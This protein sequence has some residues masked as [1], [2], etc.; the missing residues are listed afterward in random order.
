MISTRT[1]FLILAGV[2]SFVW[3]CGPTT[4]TV[5]K[6]D[7][8]TETQPTDETPEEDL[9]T[10]RIVEVKEELEYVEG[11]SEEAQDHFRLGVQKSHSVPPDYEAA[12]ESFEEAIDEEKGFMEAYFNLAMV[13]ERMRRQDKALAVYQRALKENPDSPDA[14]A[15]IGKI[16][17]ANARDL[18]QQGKAQ[19]AKALMEQGKSLFDEVLA[20][21]YENIPANN[22]LALYWLLNNDTEQAEEY[23]RQVLI[24]QPSNVTA[25]NTRG[26]IFLQANKLNIAQWI[27]EAKVLNEDPNSVEALTNLGVV[28]IRQ[29]NLPRAVSLLKRA[30]QLDPSNVAAR[31]NL[32][33]IF[34]DYLNY[35]GAQAHYEYVLEAQP[36]NVEAVIGL[37]T[38]QLAKGDFKAAVDGYQAAYKLDPRRHSLLLKTAKLYE[39]KFAKDEDGMK[40]AIGFYEQYA[41]A[42]NL[43]PEHKIRKTIFVLKDMIAKGMLREPPPEPELPEGESDGAET[44]AEE[45]AEPAPAEKPAEPAPAKDST[46]EPAAEP[47]PE[48]EPAA[49]PAPEATP[50]K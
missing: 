23:V 5:R 19:E 40:V 34:I 3:A 35:D 17:L 33:S 6:A 15:F 10:I 37:A 1:K 24:A 45:A 13:Y 47:T 28:Y 14:K 21:D 8:T 27:F 48:P 36:T 43:N 7:G 50:S 4:H 42:A 49:E 41:T 20:R 32:G 29:D 16:H 25:L 38:A 9:R 2:I 11:L 46:P 18:Q 26:L 12:A 31:M 44:P 39:Q 22:A 30:I